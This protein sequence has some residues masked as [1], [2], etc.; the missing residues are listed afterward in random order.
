MNYRI[1]F[2]VAA[3]LTVLTVLGALTVC[4]VPTTLVWVGVT[5]VLMVS[6]QAFL[7]AAMRNIAP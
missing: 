4:A 1:A 5:F 7:T 2:P 6:A 3:V